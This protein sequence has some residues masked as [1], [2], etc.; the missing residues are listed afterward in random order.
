MYQHSFNSKL[1]LRWTCFSLNKELCKERSISIACSYMLKNYPTREF[2]TIKE[3]FKPANYKPDMAKG[4]TE[5]KKS[6]FTS[7]NNLTNSSTTLSTHR[8]FKALSIN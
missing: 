6:N 5:R 7:F 3:P 4:P 8:G 2:D 1:L